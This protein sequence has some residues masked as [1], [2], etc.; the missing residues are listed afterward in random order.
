MGRNERA[1]DEEKGRDSGEHHEVDLY[2]EP[3]KDE[4]TGKPHDNDEHPN[5]EDLRETDDPNPPDEQEGDE[6]DRWLRENDK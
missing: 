4:A 3:H 5:D 6:A 1:K 2:D